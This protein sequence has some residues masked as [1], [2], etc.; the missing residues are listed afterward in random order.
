MFGQ[1]TL[2]KIDRIANEA[3]NGGATPGL[4]VLVAKDGRIVYNKAF[5]YHTYR[6][7]VPYATDNVY[8]MASVTKICASTILIY[9]F[10]LC[11]KKFYCNI[12]SFFFLYSSNLL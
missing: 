3:I 7:Q 9:S 1:K 11:F 8:D 5:G 4:Q 10:T 2:S 6:K 12:S